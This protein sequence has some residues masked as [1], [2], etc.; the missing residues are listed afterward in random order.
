MEKLFILTRK[1][2]PFAYQ[3]VQSGH[4]VAQWML[5]NGNHHWRN[6]TL[7]YLSVPDEQHLNLWCSKLES[8]GHKFSQFCEPDINNEKTSI[9]CYTDGKIFSNLKLMGA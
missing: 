1:D 9:A 3:A 5:E 8:K 6:Q 4:A 7:V 2:M